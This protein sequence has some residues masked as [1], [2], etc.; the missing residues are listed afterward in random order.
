M[1][2]ASSIKRQTA[3]IQ[4]N[5]RQLMRGKI[6]RDIERALTTIGVVVANKALEY[7]PVEFSLLV[8]SQYQI[9]S[10]SPT[11]YSVRVGY[12]QDYAAPLHER[13]DWSPRQPDMKDGPAWN[14]NA[15]TKFLTSAADEERPTIT[16]IMLGDLRL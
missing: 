14:P 12:T 9:L 7:T 6:P 16:R 10:A 3:A 15:K 5:A 1:A 2:T 4:R 8:N 11:S 13:T